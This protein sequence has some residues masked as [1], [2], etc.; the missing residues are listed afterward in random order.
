M[1]EQSSQLPDRTTIH[2]PQVAEFPAEKTT[3]DPLPP[4][5]QGPP[6][7]DQLGLPPGDHA[8][9]DLPQDLRP[10]PRLTSPAR[11]GKRLNPASDAQR[12]PFTPQRLVECLRLPSR[13]LLPCRHLLYERA[14]DCRVRSGVEE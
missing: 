13:T 12:T 8:D 7:D 4:P 1:S 10:A 3:V 9:H 5:S 2:D 11:H 6:A 14:G